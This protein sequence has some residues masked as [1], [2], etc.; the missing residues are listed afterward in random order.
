MIKRSLLLSCLLLA[1]ISFIHAQELVTKVVVNSQR[2]ASSVDKKR[3]NTLQTQLT[4]FLNSRKWTGDTYQNNEKIQCYFLLNLE[5][6][7]ETDVYKASLTIQVARPVFNSS[8][9]SPLINY[10]DGD[11]TFKYVEFQPVEF[12]E[13]R[14]QG[15]DP[16]A[17]NLT[18]IFAYYSYMILGF[19]YDSY[20]LKGGDQYFKKA[21]N[22]VNNAPESRNITGWKV[23][24]GLRNRYWLVNNMANPKNNTLHDVFYNYYHKGLDNMYDNPTESRNQVIDALSKLQ[25]FN[26]DNPNTMI[27]Q[28]FLQNRYQEMT[29]IFKNA[30]P[31]SK[32]KAG[33]LLATLDVSNSNRYKQ[34]LR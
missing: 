34:D 3:F 9:Q 33:D 12:N 16:Q 4:T 17:A 24:D 5:S 8:Y 11:V 18:A 25:D 26:Q 22:I 15:T 7:V 2:I 32:A 1:C 19:D 31:Q 10:Q 23:F 27:V 21:Q 13:N 29:G 14:V 20:S 30:D 6:I 28:F